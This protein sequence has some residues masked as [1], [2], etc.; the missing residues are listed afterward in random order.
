VTESWVVPLGGQLDLLALWLEPIVA[1]PGLVPVPPEE[2]HIVVA[3]AISTEPPE[4]EP[5]DA[6]VGPVR[7]DA[8]GVVADVIPVEPFV[9]LRARLGAGGDFAPRVV[10]ARADGTRDLEPIEAVASEAVLVGTVTL[11]DA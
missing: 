11:R 3:P 1:R 5:F 9:A 8:N 10:F 4:L 6:L 2:L 7:V